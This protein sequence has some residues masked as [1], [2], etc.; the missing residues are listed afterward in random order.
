MV[1]CGTPQ[2]D[3]PEVVT[4]TKPRGQT[5]SDRE[6]RGRH[7]GSDNQ[8]QSRSTAS[9]GRHKGPHK[10]TNQRPTM[11]SVQSI[12]HVQHQCYNS[13]C[14]RCLKEYLATSVEMVPLVAPCRVLCEAEK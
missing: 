14:I 8:M 3:S 10:G 1:A 9:G 2:T 5:G 13:L 12:I 6:H 11:L 4:D 7:M